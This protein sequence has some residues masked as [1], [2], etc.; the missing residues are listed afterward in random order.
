MPRHEVLELHVL[1]VTEDAWCPVCLLATAV[2][3]RW[4]GADQVTLAVVVRGTTL[5]C[6]DCGYDHV[7]P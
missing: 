7:A 4:V 3:V 2:E 6:D 1:G 5:F